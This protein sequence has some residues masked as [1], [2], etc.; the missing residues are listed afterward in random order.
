MYFICVCHGLGCW[1]CR[2]WPV[3]ARCRREVVGPCPPFP[4]PLRFVPQCPA[5]WLDMGVFVTNGLG[6]MNGCAAPSACARGFVWAG[7]SPVCRVFP[8]ACAAVGGGGSRVAA[9]CGFKCL[10]CPAAPAPLPTSSLS[11]T[12]LAPSTTSICSFVC[13]SM[14][15]EEGQNVDLYI[16]RKWCVASQ[17]LTWRSIFAAPPPP[18]SMQRLPLLLLTRCQRTLTLLQ[19]APTPVCCWPRTPC[20]FVSLFLHV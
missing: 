11:L 14:Q 20:V 17:A 9:R 5:V 4:L 12:P 13:R 15:N 2:W 19:Y 8:L 7:W 3:G 6:F 16:P 1:L 10:V 18:P